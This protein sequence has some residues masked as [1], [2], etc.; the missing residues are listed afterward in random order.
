MY[1]DE[2]LLKRSDQDYK[3]TICLCHSSSPADY[4]K[5][6]ECLHWQE[7]QYY[8]TLKYEKRKK[9]YLLGRYSAKKAFS[10]YVNE[11]NPGKILIQSGIFSQPVAVYEYGR[12]IQVSIAHCLDFGAAIAFPEAH[13]MGVDIEM[14]EWEKIRDFEEQITDNEKELIKSYYSKCVMLTVLWTVKEGLSKVLRAGLT[15]SF[16]IYEIKIIEARGK[17]LVSFFKNFGQYKAV[18]FALGKYICS[19]VYPL[20]TAIDLDV[21]SLQDSF[22]FAGFN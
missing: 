15:A 21:M 6:E 3:A 2:I 17:C 20:Q 13:P 14:A 1:I 5:M 7:Y 10:H 19:I 16:N 11:A 4:R 22:K 9:S 8:Q 12:N 18:S